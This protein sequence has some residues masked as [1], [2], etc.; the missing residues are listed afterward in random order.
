MTGKDFIE[1]S[2]NSFKEELSS[3]QKQTMATEAK[4]IR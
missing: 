2:L 1:E 3:E 4:F